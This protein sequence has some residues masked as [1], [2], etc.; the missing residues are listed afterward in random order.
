MSVHI[1]AEVDKFIACYMRKHVS[2]K[3]NGQIDVMEADAIISTLFKLL[4]TWAV[5]E[6]NVFV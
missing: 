6:G 3:K 2:A 5:E 4:M 1:F